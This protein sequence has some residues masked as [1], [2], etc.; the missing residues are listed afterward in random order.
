MSPADAKK[1]STYR[2]IVA[3]FAAGAGA[4]VL[5]GL[6]TPMVVKGGLSIRD[7]MA[8]TV[9]VHAPLIQPLDVAAVRAQIASA[10]TT[11]DSARAQTDAE[12]ARLNQLS[13]R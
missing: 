2:M 8:A 1:K 11:M 5:A 3:S 10:E 9:D 13:G 12:I 4:L 6:V 7:A